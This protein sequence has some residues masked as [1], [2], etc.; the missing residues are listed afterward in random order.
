MEQSFPAPPAGGGDMGAAKVPAA[1][2][3]KDAATREMAAAAGFDTRGGESSELPVDMTKNLSYGKPAPDT[4]LSS[5]VSG[6]AW[7]RDA[8]T[9]KS[10]A[11]LEGRTLST[12]P[13]ASAM[14]SGHEGSEAD[15]VVYPDVQA[16]KATA[17]P[18]SKPLRYVAGALARSE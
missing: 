18:H 17:H 5:G 9:G 7:E 13:A 6:E 4:M 14:P 1:P 12:T 15:H 2:T 3:M 11:Q 16:E 10:E 8:L